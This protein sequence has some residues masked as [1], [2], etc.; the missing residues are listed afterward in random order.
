MCCSTLL[1]SQ[2]V[3]AVQPVSN[4]RIGSLA[5]QEDAE[6]WIDDL[7]EL[8]TLTGR[9]RRQ[10]E[11]YRS[12]AASG[13]TVELAHLTGPSGFSRS[14]IRGLEDKGLAVVEDRIVERDTVAIAEAHGVEPVGDA[15]LFGNG[16]A[17]PG[18]VDVEREIGPLDHRLAG[19][20]ERFV[21]GRE[22]AACAQREAERDSER[23][24]ELAI[25]CLGH[26]T[27]PL[28]RS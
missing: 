4:T 16:Q 2:R 13:G 28:I 14:V 23:T 22:A 10:A 15:A 12:L 26:D 21:L 9:A 7:D 17:V 6:R 24:S 8:E 5:W 1:S 20:V 19:A 11:A 25:D 27:L 3:A 18:G